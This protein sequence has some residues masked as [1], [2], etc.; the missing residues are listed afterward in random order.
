MRSLNSQIIFQADYLR[1]EKI[2]LPL[3]VAIGDMSQAAADAKLDCV[4]SI[5]ATLRDAKLNEEE[6][7]RAM[8]EKG[9][10][11]GK[12]GDARNSHNM[13]WN[14]AALKDWQLGW[15]KG[16]SVRQAGAGA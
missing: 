15:D 11:A 3:A 4:E 6:Q 9:F 7:R 13:N 8:R 1:H 5:L 16:N 12:R 2:A 10:A 14:A